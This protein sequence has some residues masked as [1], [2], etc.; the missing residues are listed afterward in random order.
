MKKIKSLT[1][2]DKDRI[3][4]VTSEN[5]HDFYY[6]PVSTKQRYWLTSGTFHGSVFAYFRQKGRNM[7]GVG[8]SL[9]LEQLY[10]FK[11][12]R[13][14]V[15]T[16]L[17]ERIPGMVDYVIAEYVVHDMKVQAE[18]TPPYLNLSAK[19]EAYEYDLAC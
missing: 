2:N 9:T 8:F 11:D 14:P 6:Q 10:Q 19:P 7:E 12:Y 13:N 3:I 4:C 1:R 5:R 16:R 18:V 15:L 17:L